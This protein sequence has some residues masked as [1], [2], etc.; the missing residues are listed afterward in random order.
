MVT[1]ISTIIIIAPPRAAHHAQAEANKNKVLMEAAAEAE[2]IRVRSSLIYCCYHKHNYFWF[3]IIFSCISLCLCFKHT[4][5]PS[6]VVLQA[7]PY[8][9]IS[10]GNICIVCAVQSPNSAGKG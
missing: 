3:D 10:Y 5:T 9:A 7:W 1:C 2:A 6:I 4:N 8:H